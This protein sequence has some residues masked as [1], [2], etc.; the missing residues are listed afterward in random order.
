[1]NLPKTNLIRYTQPQRMAVFVLLLMIIG[2]EIFGYFIINDK[3]ES[4]SVQIP[5]EISSLQTDAENPISN[6]PAKEITKFNPNELNAQEWQELGFSPKQVQ[7]IFKY[8]NSLG[9]NFH[10]KEEIRN[11]FVVSAE[12]FAEIEPFILLSK[13]NSKESNF[14]KLNYK[15]EIKIKYRKFNPN[16]YSESDWMKIGFSEKQAQTILKYK[17]SRGGK[18]SSLEEIKKC[19]VISEEKFNEMQPF[20]FFP[21][22]LIREK[23]EENPKPETKKISKFN[24]N[25]LTR[26]DWGNLGFTEKQINT[27]LNYKNS[28]GGTFKDAET[29]K[30]CY[31]ISAEKFAEIEPYLDFNMN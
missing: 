25:N 19:Y 28:L 6:F 22:E 2:L 21:E 5:L 20:M 27:I 7:T 24:P 12:K 4:E 14:E 23:T 10:S 9:G 16:D 13:L 26:E 29:L 31:S 1:M 30:K 17:R 8:K 15:E 3:K 18:F 11:C